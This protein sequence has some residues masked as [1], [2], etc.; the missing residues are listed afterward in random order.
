MMSDCEKCWNTPCDCGWGYRNDVKIRRIKLASSVLGIDPDLL[1]LKM[2]K[3]I[4]NEH[5]MKEE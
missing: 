5:P 3:D 1:K 2:D 4:P